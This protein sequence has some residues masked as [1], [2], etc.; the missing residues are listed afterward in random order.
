[1]DSPS[2]ATFGSCLSFRVASRSPLG[3]KLQR[4]AT[5]ARD[6]GDA[7]T[8]DLVERNLRRIAGPRVELPRFA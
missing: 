2:I 5:I 8:A 4:V 1:M 7:F 3:L 6:Q